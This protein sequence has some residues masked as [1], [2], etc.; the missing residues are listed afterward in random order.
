MFASLR[1]FYWGGGIGLL[2]DFCLGLGWFGFG[3]LSGR[4]LN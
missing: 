1:G 3:F 2:E 4:V